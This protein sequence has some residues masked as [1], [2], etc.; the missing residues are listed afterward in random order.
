MNQI[1]KINVGDVIYDIRDKSRFIEIT[2]DELVSLRNNNELIAGSFYRITDYI[3]TT[4]ET[5]TRSA[6]HPF[7]IIVV[8]LNQNTLSEEAYVIQSERDVDGYFSNCN[9]AAWKIKYCLDNDASKFRWAFNDIEY[10]IAVGFSYDDTENL[11]QFDNWIRFEG[12]IQVD[13]QEELYDRGEMNELISHFGYETDSKGRRLTLYGRNIDGDLDEE[14]E[15]GGLNAEFKY[16][17]IGE[18]TIDGEI[19]DVWLDYNSENFHTLTKKIVS[20]TN[21]GKGVIY[22]MKDEYGNECSYDFKNIMFNRKITDGVIDNE[23]GI[24]TFV[25]TFSWIDVYGVFGDVNNIYDLSIKGNNG[26]LKTDEGEISG[27]YGNEI[28]NYRIK[29]A[30]SD[31]IQYGLNDNV[32]ISNYPSYDQYG[33]NGNKLLNDCRS[34]SFGDSCSHNSF[35]ED[36]YHNSFGNDCYHNS[37]GEDCYHNSFGN[38]CDNNSF[39]NGCNYNSFGDMCY[40]N[41]FGMFCYDI[42][43]NRRCLHNAL[44]SYCRNIFFGN[45]CHDNKFGNSCESNTLVEYCTYN[46]FGHMCK[47]NTLNAECSY[48]TFGIQCNNNILGPNSSFNT[49]GNKCLNNKCTI[50]VDGVASTYHRFNIFGDNVQNCTLINEKS[51]S[52]NNQVQYYNIKSGVNGE[53]INTVRNLQH[54]TIIGGETEHIFETI[55]I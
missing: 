31:K 7:D 46:I 39:G 20:V 25:Y 8:A 16:Y 19:Y 33:T 2:Y 4:S 49:F 5:D 41:S 21:I 17:Y 22:Y 55:T 9:L 1:S 28:G 14:Y 52:A 29:Y 12:N 47:N 32:F 13:T 43:F 44:G 38:K 54:E 30:E 42:N 24:D 27:C 15:D 51:A 10:D 53:T 35:G 18:D 11:Y 6:E 26:D 50:D 37:F 48:N 40:L 45:E 23:N 34:N 36:C 3:T